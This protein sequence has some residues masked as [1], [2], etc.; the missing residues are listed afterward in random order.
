MA[1]YKAPLR[2]MSFV[3]NEVFDAPSLW[4]RLPALSERVD[5]ETADAIL[6][7]AGKLSSKVLDPLNRT[8][9]EEGCHWD[10]GVVTTPKGFPEAYQTFMEGGWCG[11]GGN[12]EFGGMGMPKMMPVRL[13]RW[14]AT[15][16]RSS[17]R[18]ICPTCTPV[19]GPAP[20][21]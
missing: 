19:S 3:L 7:E 17:R 21:V 4:A 5:P 2:D 18:S 1:E 11:I 8:G 14:T 9:D 10:N 6:E 15:A 20:C 13:W 12:P 16:L